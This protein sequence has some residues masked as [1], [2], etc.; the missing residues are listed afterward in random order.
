MSVYVTGD[1]HCWVD[2]KKFTY[3]P[4]KEGDYV[5]V[6]GDFGVV[7]DIVYTQLLDWFNHQPWT[8]LF[9]DGNHE[10]FDLLNAYPVDEWNGGKVHYISHKVIHLMRGQVFTIEGKKFF[11]MGG[12]K[13]TDKHLRKEGESWWAAEMPSPM[14]YEE[15]LNNLDA[16]DNKVDYIITH[17]AP[18]EVQK[19]IAYWYDN[20]ELTKFLEIV[21]QTVK[22]E[23]HYFGHYHIDKEI[24]PKHTCLYD[25]FIKVT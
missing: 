2:K 24:G 25:E 17:C 20:D 8:T 16:N 15:A 1:L 14:E 9:V 23:H 18:T 7:F 13:S 11:T 10:G 21:R 4:A 12:A 5:I 3:C 19:E 6:C 22:F